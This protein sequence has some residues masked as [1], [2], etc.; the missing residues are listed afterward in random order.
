MDENDLLLRHAERWAAE[1]HR[2]LDVA[3]VGEALQLRSVHDGLAAN[4]WPAR[5]VTHLLLV[6]WP[7]HG[8]LDSPDVPV[9]L[10]SLETFWRFLRNTG[11]L[12]GGSAE[13]S[14]LVSEAKSAGRRMTAAC[15]DPT[16]FGPSKQML[17]FGQEIG[18][19]LDDVTD[20]DDVDE[21]L[22]RI[23]EAWNSLPT[24]ERQRRS[25][26][27]SSNAGSRAGRALGE[28]AGYLMQ[29]GELPQGWAMP[30]PP[31]LDEQLGDEQV[32]PVDPAVSAPQY[33][34]SDYLRQVLA[35]CEW[36]GEGREVT[37]TEVLRPAVAK[38]AYADLGLWGWERQWLAATGLELPGGK[39]LDAAMSQIGLS[40]WRSAGEC[41]P[42]D[43][44]WL[45]A[46]QA[47]LIVIK[48]KQASFDRAALPKS[49]VHWAQLA[50]VLLLG[51]AHR[52]E[53]ESA[54]AALLGVLFAIAWEG[55]QPRS[56]D[57]L[58]DLWWSSP[59]NWVVEGLRDSELAR[60][61]SDQHLA[62]C[63]AMFGDTGAWTVR[64]GRL[65][66]TDI[67]WDLTLV[68]M[69]AIESGVLE[70]PQ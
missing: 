4:R 25:P 48:G 37:A 13:P 40:S 67:G 57:E 26:S 62:R 38:Q 8:P 64:R 66:G 56:R 63:L 12:A 47:G 49:D 61:I 42:L 60:R 5:S 19:T 1:H 46:L 33:R 41:L 65:V 69:S 21:R 34:A 55:K 16:N 52:A 70:G 51:M 43:R 17:L 7:A 3:L 59:A 45:P 50:Q 15:A 6:R 53:P 68:V 36:V 18:I 32:Y 10:A 9:L 39:R 35:L 23:M 54:V 58:A 28:A 20:T 29:N 30:E 27:A 22:Q 2:N 44:L 11:R 24:A 31:R 14:A